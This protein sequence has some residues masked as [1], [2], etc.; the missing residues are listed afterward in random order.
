MRVVAGLYKGRTLHA[1]PGT[2][3]RPTSDKVRGAVFNVLGDIEGL[4]VLDLFAGTGALGIEALSRGAADAT[5][6]D[7]DPAPA[8]RNLDAIGVETT[9]D[10]REALRFLAKS[11]ARY[12]LVFADPPYSSAPSLGAQLTQLLPAVL[13]KNAR[14]VT[15]SDKRAPLDLAFPLEFERD[16]G[17]TRIR[18]H[19]V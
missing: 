10:R 2:S 4:R 19:R 8:Q 16:Y 1:P 13:S 14:I 15:E 9:V 5:F 17:D 3:V 18:I 12:D 7:T 6:V 11:D